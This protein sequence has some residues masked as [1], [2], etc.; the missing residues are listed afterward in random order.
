[1]PFRNG[2]DKAIATPALG[3]DD[4]LR[5]ATIAYGAPGGHNTAIPA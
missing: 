4:L 1:M 3:L 5:V 2:C